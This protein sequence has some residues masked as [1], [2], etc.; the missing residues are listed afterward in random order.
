MSPELKVML[1]GIIF[2]FAFIGL[3]GIAIDT[4]NPLGLILMVFA[5]GLKIAVNLVEK[6][7]H[8]QR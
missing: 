7:L 4:S 8:E 1:N 3:G 5:V 6:A 2:S